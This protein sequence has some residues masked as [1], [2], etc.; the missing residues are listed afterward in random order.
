MPEFPEA[1]SH[2]VSQARP[3]ARSLTAASLC[4]LALFFDFFGWILAIAGII[5]LRRAV[6]SRTVKWYLAAIAIGPKILF[7]GV[8]SLT[9]PEG[10]SI[11]IEPR[12]LATSSSLWA[13]CIFLVA[14]GGY[15]LF[16]ARRP[17]QAQNA[18]VQP[19]S[20]RSL[21]IAALGLI[22]IA[23]AVV[24]LLGLTEGFHWIHDAGRGQWA[25]RHA[26]R[27]DVATFSGKDVQAVEATERYSSRGG[28]SYAVR[29]ALADGRSFA[30]TTKSAAALD[31]LRKFAM[32]ANLPDGRVR[33]VRRRGGLWT[34]GSSGFSLQDCLGTYE[35][36]DAVGTARSTYEFW[37]D[38]ERLTGKETLAETHGRHIRNLS[39]IKISDSGEFE[40]QASPYFEAARQDKGT[41]SLSFGWSSKGETGRFVK[42]GLEVGLQ[43]YRKQ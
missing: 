28:S 30:V 18:P 33:I 43:K 19:S 12:N 29:I 3:D 23:V 21:G 42:N 22:A 5:L 4:V 7:V 39:N 38:G 9:A 24:L 36:A 32:T 16:E 17:P 34:N 14:F 31:E 25:L 10:L 2:P 35:G 41:V 6:F 8:R 15:L 13:W 37:L 1:Q 20:Y 11:P 27:G 40:F 26:V